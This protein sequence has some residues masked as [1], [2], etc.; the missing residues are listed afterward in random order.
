MTADEYQDTPELDSE[1]A[2]E[3]LQWCWGDGYT[4]WIEPSTGMWLASARTARALSRARARISSAPRSSTTGRST[5]RRR[6]AARGHPRYARHVQ[7]S[8]PKV[9]SAS[10]PRPASEPCGR[11]FQQV[12]CDAGDE[13]SV[14]W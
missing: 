1:R 4:I 11:V 2:L 9:S 8:R 14:L 10:P 5:R 7:T 3:A 12:A 13:R 6:G